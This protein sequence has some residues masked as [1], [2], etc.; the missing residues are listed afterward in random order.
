[1]PRRAFVLIAAVVCLAF[2]SQAAYA[3]STWLTAADNTQRTADD[4][5][6]P[7]LLPL[8]NAWNA[9]LDATVY[10]QPVVYDGRVFAATENNTVY[11][12][13]AHDGHA[14]W[15][16]HL[17]PPMTNVNAQVGCGNVD[18]LGILSTPAIDPARNTIYVVATIQGTFGHIHH[19]LVGLDTLTGIPLESAN[20]DPGGIQNSLYIQQ[21]TGLAVANGRVYIG[22]GGYAGDCGPYHGWLV[23]LTEAA[24]G[25]VAFDV[26][27]HGTEGAIW[28]PGGVSVDSGG[29]VYAATGNPDPDNSGDFGESLLK[30]DNTS[31]MHLKGVLKTFPGGDDDLASV[32]PAQLGSHLIF[33]VGKH[34][35]GYLVDT[36]T[37]TIVRS[38]GMCAGVDAD[39]ADAWDGGHLFVPCNDGIQQVNVNIGARTMGLGWKGPGVGSPIIAGNVIWTVDWNNAQ[40]YALNRASGATLAGFPIAINSTPH[41]TSPSAALGLILI[42]THAGVSAYAGPAGV[43]PHAP[44]ACV[45]QKNHTGYWVASTDGNVFPF[46]GA[47]SCGIV[48]GHVKAPIIGIAGL[49]TPGY[50]LAATDGGVFSFG[51]ALYH[52]SMAGKPLKRP[53]V[54]IAATPSGNGYWLV[55]SDGGIFNFGGAGYHGSAGGLRLN[56]PVVGMAATRTGRGYYLVAS[57]GGI[58]TYGDAAYHG[59]TGG[60]RLNKPIIGMV[61]TPTGKGYWLVASD[62]GVFTFGDAVYHGSTGGLHLVSPILGAS[63]GGNGYWLVAGD[64]GVFSFDAPFHGSA[65]GLT[66]GTFAIAISHD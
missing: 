54:G 2:A 52:G 60:R 23:S 40:L 13:D 49:G 1:M 62:G 11:A 9:A 14:L 27:P 4:T 55:A 12:L 64:G 44:N 22:Y 63:G 18:P 30:F 36:T 56:R 43:P 31:G 46:G 24:T 38:L 37:M 57:D 3:G 21:R 47:P 26:T 33:Q 32:S 66:T 17:G 61:L 8:H 25:K 20:A 16:R 10:G 48:A 42:G 58:F 59:S 41:F 45:A 65:V 50:W 15:K 53:I 19:Q 51:T 35:I 7:G 6:E 28:A 39:G 34:H 5:T 29:F